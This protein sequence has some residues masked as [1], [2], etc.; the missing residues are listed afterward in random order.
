M[1]EQISNVRKDNIDQT[2]K[3]KKLKNMQ[4]TQGKELETNNLLKKFPNQI[5]SYTDEIKNLMSKKQEHITKI[6]NNKKS[7]FNLK[8]IL[9]NINKNYEKIIS[10]RSYQKN[11]DNTVLIN[12][13]EESLNNIKKDLTMPDEEL[14]EKINNLQ[15]VNKYTYIN[16]EGKNNINLLNVPKRLKS[17]T[18]IKENPDLYN[19]NNSSNKDFKNDFYKYKLGANSK[20]KIRNK[21]PDLALLKIL[22]PIVNK[23]NKE[24]IS[25]P[26]RGIFH[27]YEYLNNK[28]KLNN[29]NGKKVLSSIKQN[30]YINSTKINKKE[31]TEAR[32]II[33]NKNLDSGDG[34][35]KIFNIIS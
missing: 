5:N 26:Y 12:S 6:S 7:L 15:T 35:T 23:T 22:P 19:N 16:N 18:M 25:S 1:E 9:S 3:L 2:N 8:N 10:G 34:K 30:A 20:G 32:K 24:I 4:Y 11:G 17:K 13:I 31:S 14:L 21:S 33:D 29:N 27:K 28:D